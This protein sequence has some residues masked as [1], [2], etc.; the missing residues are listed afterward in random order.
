MGSRNIVMGRSTGMQHIA[1]VG[2]VAAWVILLCGCATGGADSS[3][4]DGGGGCI[5]VDCDSTCQSTGYPGGLCTEEDLC[6]CV[7]SDTD[8]DADSDADSDS[9]SDTDTDSDSDTDADADAGADGGADTDTEPAGPPLALFFRE[10][11]TYLTLYEGHELLVGPSGSADPDDG[12]WTVVAAADV[13]EPE[14]SGAWVLG[15]AVSL[16]AF[17]GGEV[18]VAFR[19]TGDIADNW[20]IDDVCVASTPDLSAYPSSC[21]LFSESFDGATEPELPEGWTS[22][23]GPDSTSSTAWSTASDQASTAPNSA[24]IPGDSGVDAFLVSPPFSLPDA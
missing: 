7:G 12:A 6:E 9:D 18:R 5:P 16:S 1:N 17:A 8:T 13:M 20:W 19:F 15:R 24:V 23:P 10:Y 14:D 22:V 4:G 11:G 2:T 21:D 3:G